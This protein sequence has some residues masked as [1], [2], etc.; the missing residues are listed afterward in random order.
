MKIIENGVD[1]L[2][3]VKHQTYK[4]FLGRVPNLKNTDKALF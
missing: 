1:N 2:S 4:P 3:S